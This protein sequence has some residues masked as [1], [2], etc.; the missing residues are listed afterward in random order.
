MT[1]YWTS[2]YDDPEGLRWWVFLK[3]EVEPR[4][5]FAEEKLA[6]GFCGMMNTCVWLVAKGH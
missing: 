3:G 1:E 5:K 6:R 2:E 4:A